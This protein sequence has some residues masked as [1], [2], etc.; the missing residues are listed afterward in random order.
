ME[1]L[2]FKIR[3]NLPG[4]IPVLCLIERKKGTASCKKTVPV[5]V[6]SAFTVC[7]PITP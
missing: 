6:K 2:R 1:Q 4:R 3:R 5:T 7:Y